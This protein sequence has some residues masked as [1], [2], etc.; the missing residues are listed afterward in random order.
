MKK[1]MEGKIANYQLADKKWIL[2]IEISGDE[3]TEMGEKWGFR[4]V[5]ITIE[6]LP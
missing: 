2:G 5:R 1:V 3:W 4:R 6:E